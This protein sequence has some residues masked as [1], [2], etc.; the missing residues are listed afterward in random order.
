[1]RDNLKTYKDTTVCS[2]P[3]RRYLSAGVV[4]QKLVVGETETCVGAKEP[5]KSHGV[6]VVTLLIDTP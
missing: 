1:M 4:A 5:M 6:E 2:T 3:M